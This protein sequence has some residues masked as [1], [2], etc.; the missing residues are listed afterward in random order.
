MQSVLDSF[1][2]RPVSGSAFTQARYKVSSE[3]FKELCQIPLQTYLSSKKKT[4]KGHSLLAGDGSSLLLPSSKSIQNHFGIH[5]STR[6]GVNRCLSRVFFVYDVLNDFVV[7]SELSKMEKGE[8]TLLLRCL[9]NSVQMDSI[10]ILDRGFGNYCT[11]KELID[12]KQAFCVRLGMK[13]SNF[14]KSILNEENTDFITTWVPSPK[15]RE[16][17]V[18]LGLNPVP[19]EVRVTK[20]KLKTGEMELLVTSLNNMKKYKTVDI[21]KL[22]GLRWGVEEA[23]KN[24]KPKMKIEQFGCK[25]P[26]GVMQEFYAHVFCMNMIALYGMTAGKIVERKTKNRRWVYKYNWKNAYRFYREKVILLLLQLKLPTINKL[27]DKIAS[28]MVAIKPN[29]TFPRD[30]KHGTLHARLSQSYK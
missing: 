26:E 17:S 14:A 8:K 28:S 10:L 11:I 22:Y 30:T 18:K 27:I 5:S 4:W 15:E 21:A 16:N 25:K 20:V 19:I 12:R 24:L 9:D 1:T 3:F 6:F 2:D 29:R 13:N 23:F 7:A